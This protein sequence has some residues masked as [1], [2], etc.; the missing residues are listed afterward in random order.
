MSVSVQMPWEWILMHPRVRVLSSESCGDFY[1][2]H[3]R[4][5]EKFG[6]MVSM[7]LALYHC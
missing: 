5:E 1:G 6:K 2:R 7:L 3:K 4:R